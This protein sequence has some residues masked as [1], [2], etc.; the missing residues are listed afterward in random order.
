MML[1]IALLSY[2]GEPVS[3]SVAFDDRDRLY[4]IATD[5]L[6]NMF[7]SLQNHL[8]YENNTPDYGV[9]FPTMCRSFEDS[10][11]FSINIVHK[12]LLVG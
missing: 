10:D 7:E 3:L 1:S 6:V 9:I 5:D 2:C 4:Y 11:Y 8:V 12:S